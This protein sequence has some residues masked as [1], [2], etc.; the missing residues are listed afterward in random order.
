MITD[1]KKTY[2][3]STRPQTYFFEMYLGT[4]WEAFGE[5]EAEEAS[6]RHLEVRSQKID[7][8]LS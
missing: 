7:A 2:D 4:L 1:A 5:L 3:P 8:P 6:G